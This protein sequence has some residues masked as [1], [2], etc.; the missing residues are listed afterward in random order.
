M[1]HKVRFHQSDENAFDY[2]KNSCTVIY[3]VKYVKEVIR[4]G[5]DVDFICDRRAKEYKTDLLYGARLVDL[6]QLKTIASRDQIRLTIIICVGMPYSRVTSEIYCELRESDIDAD[7]FDW[8]NTNCFFDSESFTYGGVRMPLFEHPY[9]CGYKKGRMTE[10]AIELAI[11]NYWLGKIDNDEYVTEVGAVT[12]YYFFDDRIRRIIDPSDEHRLVTE[13]KSVY[14]ISLQ[15]ENVLSIST[16]E[17]VGTGEYGVKEQRD[18]VGAIEK[19]MEEAKKYLISVP[20]GY[21]KLLDK[22][23]KKYRGDKMIV[24]GRGMNNEWH[25]LKSTE[26]IDEYQYSL[27]ANAVCF[28][29]NI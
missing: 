2:M 16:L 5:I 3:G 27:W 21:N 7:V 15:N 11:T 22:W 1:S 28:F 10:R 14:D 29:C 18:A 13:K 17:H 8:F 23:I 26:E 19:V 4:C 24:L 6:H 25:N 9:N 12:P 20:Y